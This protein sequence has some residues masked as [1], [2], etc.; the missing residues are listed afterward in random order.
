MPQSRGEEDG[1]GERR[2]ERVALR[3]S[4]KKG[5][6]ETPHP[7]SPLWVRRKRKGRVGQE[8]GVVGRV[9]G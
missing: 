8:G 9:G 2:A 1:D 6:V 4:V 3:V 5:Q 7:L